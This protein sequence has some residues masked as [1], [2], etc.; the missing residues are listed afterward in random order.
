MA[1]RV[2]REDCM[3]SP[4]PKGMFEKYDALLLPGDGVRISRQSW[5][6]MS[7]D[8]QAKA[9]WQVATH[10]ACNLLKPVTM[11]VRIRDLDGKIYHRQQVST[12]FAC[13]GDQAVTRPGATWYR[14]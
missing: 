14:C 7:P 6:R 3:G 11:T 5:A 4:A 9:I 13:H 2:V 1:E 12:E 8:E 10:T